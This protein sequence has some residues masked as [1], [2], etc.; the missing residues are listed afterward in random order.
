RSR[1]PGSPADASELPSR[2]EERGAHHATLPTGWKATPRGGDRGA[3]NAVASIGGGAGRA[4]DV[5]PGSR[6]RGRC[7]FSA[8]RGGCPT[9]RVR[10]TFPPASL[11][12]KPQSSLSIEF[13]LGAIHRRRRCSTTT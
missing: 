2:G 10:G 1:R 8:Q 7:G 11:D 4:V 13:W 5:A 6:A 9:E 12:A 3:R